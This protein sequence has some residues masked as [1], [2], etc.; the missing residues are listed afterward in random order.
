VLT[1]DQSKPTDQIKG[2]MV[3]SYR[4][5]KRGVWMELKEQF[6]AEQIKPLHDD[7]IRIAR[8]LQKMCN[9]SL[10]IQER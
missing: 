2:P 10:D 8:K 3:R 4:Q 7:K 1:E 5:L 6:A 9:L